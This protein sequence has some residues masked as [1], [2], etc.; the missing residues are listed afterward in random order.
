MNFMGHTRRTPWQPNVSPEAILKSFKD[1][2]REDA[3]A[4]ILLRMN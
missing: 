2:E 3:V 1:L 4:R